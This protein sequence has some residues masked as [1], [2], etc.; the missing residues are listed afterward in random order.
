MQAHNPNRNLPAEVETGS[1][2]KLAKSFKTQYGSFSDGEGENIVIFAKNADKFMRRNL[3]PSLEMGMIVIHNLKGEPYIRARRWRD[4]MDVDP[5]RAHADHWSEQPHQPAT[6]FLAFMPMQVA[7]PLIAPRAAGVAQYG[8]PDA[9]DPGHPGQPELPFRPMRP[10]VPAVREQPLVDVNHCLRAYL[11]H[12]FQKRIDIAAADKYLSTFKTQKPRQTCGTFI[13]LFMTKFEYYITVR[14]S[15]AER[16]APGFRT[17]VDQ[18]RLQYIRDGLC[19]EFRKHLDANLNII[20]QQ[21]VDDE[22]QRWSRETV[23]GREFFKACDKTEATHAT[24]SLHADTEDFQTEEEEIPQELS[25]AASGDQSQR[26]GAYR[27]R[28]G[29]A[30]G[31]GQNPGNRHTSIPTRQSKD[32]DGINNYQQSGDGKLIYNTRG[33]LLCNY[34]GIPSHPRSA[35]RHRIRDAENGLKRT[36]HPARGTM[37]SNNQFRREAQAKSVAAADQWNPRAPTPPHQNQNHQITQWQGQNGASAPMIITV[38]NPEDQ[39]WLS[40]VTS[41]GCDPASVITSGRKRQQQQTQA[42]SQATM[43][44]THTAIQNGHRVSSLLPSGMVACNECGETYATLAQT[45]DHY[46]NVH[47]PARQALTYGSESQ[48]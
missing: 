5:E 3:T 45:S 46:Y 11:L 17:N 20:T 33:H 7:Q 48:S 41:S 39:Q 2:E 13:D 18:I 15:A 37:A 26:G 40:Q 35:C 8:Q 29:G 4:T 42:Q 43:S 38:T 14:W 47:T 23:E 30:R 16:M 9:N 19:K 6:P 44:P 36:S 25:S 10:N 31:R 24:S 34:C 21:Q 22:I 32:S 28:G 12:T 27:G 1:V